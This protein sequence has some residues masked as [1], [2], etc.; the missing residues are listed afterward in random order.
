MAKY[1]NEVQGMEFYSTDDGFAIYNIIPETK[2]LYIEAM[3]MDDKCSKKEVND[4]LEVIFNMAREQGCNQVT[5]NVNTKKERAT[6]R[7]LAHI[8]RGYKVAGNDGDYI[9]MY[10]EI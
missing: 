8:R 10:K 3:S 2:T 5:G 4:F 9:V 7:V 6:T 1:M